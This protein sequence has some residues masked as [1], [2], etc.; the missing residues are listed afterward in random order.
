[1]IET[2]EHGGYPLFDH[3]GKILAAARSSGRRGSR[4]RS[5]SACAAAT[6]SSSR[7]RTWRSATTTT[8]PRRSPS[9]W[10][11][12]SPSSS[13]RR[14][15]RR[16]SVSLSGADPRP[17]EWGAVSRRRPPRRLLRL[18]F[19]L[20]ESGDLKCRSCDLGED[21]LLVAVGEPFRGLGLDLEQPVERPL[22]AVSP[23]SS[24]P[25]LSTIIGVRLMWPSSI[26]SIVPDFTASSMSPKID[27]RIAPETA[28]CSTSGIRDHSRVA[29]E[30]ATGGAVEVLGGAAPLLRVDELDA[31]VFLEHPH[32]VGDQVQTL[33]QLLGQEVGARHPLVQND[34]DLNAQRMSERL[35]DDL[36][37][38]VLLFRPGHGG[39]SFGC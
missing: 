25:C 16:R 18:G 20:A 8:T 1:M 32:V 10:R 23:T 27:C 28:G 37:N 19:A 29:E 24:Q 5:W 31:V 13:R 15:R 30:L 17:G 2:A 21:A 33:V 35:G 11:R 26:S 38:V 6:S 12:A 4:A 39:L 22:R 7:G 3:L 9:T 14:R 36:F 34:Q